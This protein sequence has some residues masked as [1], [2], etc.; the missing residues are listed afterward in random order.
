[1]TVLSDTEEDRKEAINKWLSIGG[2]HTSFVY[3]RAGHLTENYVDGNIGRYMWK[4]AVQ[5]RVYLFQRRIVGQRHT[6]FEYTAVKADS[7][8]IFRM[9]TRDYGYN[10]K[11]H[12][13]S[14][15]GMLV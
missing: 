7:P 14:K 3:A 15:K 13:K 11:E 8:P 4:L 10:D 6:L 12:R 1:M 9:V 5:G 2:V